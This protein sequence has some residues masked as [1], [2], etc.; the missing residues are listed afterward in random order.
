MLAV[1]PAQASA[2]LHHPPTIE[3]EDPQTGDALMCALCPPGT[4]V[5]AP[6]SRTLPTECAP[7]PSGHYTQFWNF[8]HRCLPCRAPCDH[9][10]RERNECAPRADRECE[11]APGYYWRAEQCMRHTRCGPGFGAKRNGTAHTDTK[12]ERC[13]RGTFSVGNSKHAQCTPHTG[14]RAHL[15]KVLRGTSWHDDVCMSC[16]QLSSGRALTRGLVLTFFTHENLNVRKLKRLV[17]LLGKQTQT[18]QLQLRDGTSRQH[19]LYYISEW[20]EAHEQQHGK[21]LEILEK[22]QLRK[23]AKKLRKMLKEVEKASECK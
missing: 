14:C 5:R 21:L 9:N 19:L 2:G 12:C 1:L 16:A 23:T 13:T 10:Q 8:L 6:C 7:C 20:T 11:C 15:F 18:G 3:Y 4:R 17:R 22:M